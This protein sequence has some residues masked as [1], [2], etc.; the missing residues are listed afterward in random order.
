MSSNR[1]LM[2]LFVEKRYMTKTNKFYESHILLWAKLCLKSKL[3]K[4]D[5]TSDR[6]D[7][8]ILVYATFVLHIPF[9]Y[10]GRTISYPI[11][12]T[13]M[14]IWDDKVEPH[15]VNVEV[16]HVSV[17][18]NL[19]YETRYYMKILY[20]RLIQKFFRINTWSN[21]CLNFGLY[22]TNEFA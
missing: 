3:P 22:I 11:T 15:R 6:M 19:S 1:L 2:T 9:F 4:R 14:R 12:S 7:N 13:S 5:L 17:L 20:N 10:F 18:H 16:W 21:S 8:E